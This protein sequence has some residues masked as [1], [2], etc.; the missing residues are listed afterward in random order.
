MAAVNPG[1]AAGAPG[2]VNPPPPHVG[3]GAGATQDFMEALLESVPCH[4]AP[5][6]DPVDSPRA[7]NHLGGLHLPRFGSSLPVMSTAS[8]PTAPGLLSAVANPGAAA[9]ALGTVNPPPPNVAGAAPAGQAMV[10][11]A[12]GPRI[13]IGLIQPPPPPAGQAMAAGAPPA[14]QAMAVG[15]PAGHAIMDAGGGLPN[16]GAG[17]TQDYGSLDGVRPLP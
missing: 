3:A 17:A 14:G 5:G 11:G 12:A 13:G 10:A 7:I 6:V 8:A 2:V 9:G 1:A 15:G 4:E 16:L